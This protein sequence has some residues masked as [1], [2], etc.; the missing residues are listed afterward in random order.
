MRPELRKSRA[1]PKAPMPFERFLFERVAL[2]NAKG[3]TAAT[4]VRPI[5]N[6]RMEA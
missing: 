4:T 5:A 3:N 6:G 1:Q 2:R